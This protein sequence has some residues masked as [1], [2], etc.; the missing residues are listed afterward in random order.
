MDIGKAQ[1]DKCLPQILGGQGNWKVAQPVCHKSLRTL[2]YIQT[3][4][5]VTVKDD[6]TIYPAL[7][8]SIS[9]TTEW[10]Y[11]LTEEQFAKL[12]WPQNLATAFNHWFL[13]DSFPNCCF[14][15][16]YSFQKIESP[17]HANRKKKSVFSLSGNICLPS[18]LDT[19]S[20][21]FFSGP[22][23]PALKNIYAISSS[24]MLPKYS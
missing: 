3:W 20:S 13:Q 5:F 22:N 14:F 4:P 15:L 7:S 11:I 9:I 18:C 21:F 10:K 2:P 6:R 8:S 19:K 24:S 16:I 23:H 1:N 12:N 17:W